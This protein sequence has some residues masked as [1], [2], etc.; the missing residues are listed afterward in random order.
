MIKDICK[1]VGFK[2]EFEDFFINS[3]EELKKNEKALEI[4]KEYAGMML[5]NER[6]DA[7]LEEIAALT[8]IHMSTVHVLCALYAMPTTE[9]MI[10]EKGYDK[11]MFDWIM[12]DLRVKC[13]ETYTTTKVIGSIF[14]E[15]YVGQL[16]LNRICLGRLQYEYNKAPV[17]MGDIK[18][19]EKIINCH[20]PSGDPL[21][22]N[23]V[24]DSL[25]KAYNFF[26][27]MRK[28]GALTIMCA[29][30]MLHP[31][32]AEN[33]FLPGSN[34]R[35]FYDKFT[36]VKS[37]EAPKNHNFWRIC[38]CDVSEIDTA[39]QETGLQRRLIKMIKNG[40]NM[41]S[42]YGYIKFDGEKIIK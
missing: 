12:Y 36:I 39:P 2:K 16:S 4:L 23:S 19:G 41:G 20:I 15:W 6:C 31:E 18:E 10:E 14:Y 11:E 17:D 30:W 27:D 3:F 9:K 32:T 42:G 33:C 21:T 7:K 35:N 37:Q 28:D 38:G 25:K 26:D 5:K 13:D 34:L 24:M 1:R 22:D 8:G 29:S 40:I